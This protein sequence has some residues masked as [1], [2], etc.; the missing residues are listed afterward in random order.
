MCLRKSQANTALA[1]SSERSLL[2]PWK[3]ILVK[4]NVFS[5]ILAQ[6]VCSSNYAV[7][8]NLFHSDSVQAET[9][10]TYILLHFPKAVT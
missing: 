7:V 10:M 4:I 9:K 6:G 5:F 3:T 1:R 2:K 8:Y